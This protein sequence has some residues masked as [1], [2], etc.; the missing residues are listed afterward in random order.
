MIKLDE[1]LEKQLNKLLSLLAL[2]Q[3]EPSLA[4]RTHSLLSVGLLS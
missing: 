2:W 1:L 3:A 4:Y